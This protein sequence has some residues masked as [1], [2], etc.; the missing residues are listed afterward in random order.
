MIKESV[1]DN[2]LELCDIIYYVYNQAI[3]KLENPGIYEM[4]HV[5]LQQFK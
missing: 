5:H 1:F 2:V 3:I 4:T